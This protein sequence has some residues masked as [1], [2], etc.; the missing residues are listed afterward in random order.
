MWHTWFDRDLGISGRVLVRTK[1][2]QDDNKEIIQQKFI[3]VDKPIARV[4]T[5][6]IHLQSPEERS[7]FAVNKENHLSPILATQKALENGVK[8]QLEGTTV[9]T[10][11][12]D[13]ELTDFWQKEQEPLLLQL[14]ANELNIQV[15]DIA[16]FELNLF[17]TQPASLG[18]IHNEFLYSARLDNLATCF[19]SVEALLK[20]TNSGNEAFVDDEDISMVCLFDH[21]EVGSRKYGTTIVVFITVQC[22]YSLFF[23]SIDIFNISPHEN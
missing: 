19:V 18:G 13:A 16:D 5:L 9:V 6:A 8:A 21:E 14:I 4:S 12:G 7:G 23:G 17:D 15:K 2:E 11:K 22:L 1:S 10:G 20:H 3:K